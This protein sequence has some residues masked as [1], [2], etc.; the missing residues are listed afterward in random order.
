MLEAQYWLLGCPFCSLLLWLNC[1]CRPPC[2]P[3]ER[4]QRLYCLN[5]IV[6]FLPAQSSYWL[7]TIDWS[8]KYS[9]DSLLYNT[10]KPKEIQLMKQSKTFTGAGTR[11]W[12]VDWSMTTTINDYQLSF[13]K[14][15]SDEDDEEVRGD[16]FT[17][18]SCDSWLCLTPSRCFLCWLV[19]CGGSGQSAAGSY[20]TWGAFISK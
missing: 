4:T 11:G 19:S 6:S 16:L 18:L 1:P 5:V 20:Q 15:N 8:P 14:I 7:T 10:P 13:L 2:S 17:L 9:L 3:K 12:L